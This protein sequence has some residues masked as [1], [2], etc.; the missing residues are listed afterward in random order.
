MQS[1]IWRENWR[2][3]YAKGA[4]FRPEFTG[5]MLS[6]GLALCALY[7]YFLSYTK[8]R[9]EETVQLIEE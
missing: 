3:E 5:F 9:H 7:L 8:V 4:S 6:L 2:L 1:R